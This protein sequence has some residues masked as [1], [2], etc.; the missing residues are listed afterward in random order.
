MDALAALLDGPR[1]QQAFLLKAVFE[2]CWSISIED[3]AALSVVVMAR[4]SAVVSTA[5]VTHAVAEG[6]VVLLRG[7]RPYVFAD[8]AATEPG[9][10]I[11]PG[12]V[13]VD[14]AGQLLD[15]SM[16]LGVRTWGNTEAEDATVMLI[17]TY[18]EET[19][20][21][22]HVLAHLPEAVVLRDLSTPAIGMLGRELEREVPGQ[23]AVLDRLLDLVLIEALRA[24]Y[25]ADDLR[26]WP[27]GQNDPLI[28]HTLG[29]I[30][31]R[32][33]QAWTVAGLAAEVGLSRAAFARRFAERIGEPPLAYLTRWRMA[34]AAD[35]LVGTDLT[36][37]VVA[38]RVGYANAFALSAAFKRLRGTSPAHFRAE[39]GR[40]G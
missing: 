13:C 39:S 38:G 6:D 11:L 32:P 20:V 9:I 31:E 22:A 4:G 27:G 17:G 19:A 14:P 3:G 1:A 29:L 23:A 24:A 34:L 15:S 30:H 12:Q 28:G 33:D 40:T 10:R 35:L 7:P 26:G 21:G 36:L 37:E 5:H 25:D 18:Q 2:G 16:A 8:S